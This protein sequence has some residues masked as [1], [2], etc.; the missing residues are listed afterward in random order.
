MNYSNYHTH[1]NLCDGKDSLEELVQKAIELGCP[2]IGFSGHSYT[3]FDEDY[4]MSVEQYKEYMDEIRRLQVA[5]GGKIRILAGIEQDYYSEEIPDG[6]D[7]VIGSVHYVLKKGKYLSVDLSEED[8]CSNVRENY[9]GDFLAFAEDYYKVVGDL[10]N[11]THCD[12]IGHFDLITKYNEGNRL[13][14]THDERYVRA[15]KNALDSIEKSLADAYEAGIGTGEVLFEINTGAMARGYRKEAYPADF[16]IA[17]LFRRG[18]KLML[19]SDCHDR[20]Q[21]LFGFEKYV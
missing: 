4:C 12:V 1:S 8:F 11:K 3:S 14:D 7:Y 16:I 18:Y 2:E 9:G 15:V 6:L 17:E 20:E 13:F 10:Y 21:L 5:Y 19:N